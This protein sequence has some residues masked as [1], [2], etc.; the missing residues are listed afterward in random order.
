MLYDYIN[1]FL[2]KMCMCKNDLKF[3]QNVL[4]CSR[5]RDKKNARWNIGFNVMK[6]YTRV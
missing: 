2:K 3:S 5:Q 1:A 4:C 6:G